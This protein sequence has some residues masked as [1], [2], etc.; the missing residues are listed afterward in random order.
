VKKILFISILLSHLALVALS[1][2][3]WQEAHTI[4]MPR[5]VSSNLL[6]TKGRDELMSM[7]DTPGNTQA[8]R[9]VSHTL[10][11][12]ESYNGANVVPFFFGNRRTQL[13]I[14]ESGAGDVNPTWLHT[15][16]AD[17][18]PYK[19][20]LKM[21][22]EREVCGV[23][24]RVT[25]ALPTFH[26]GAW[27]RI[28]M[29]LI[30][31]THHLHLT[32][33][34][35]SEVTMS[36]TSTF[37]KVTEALD[38]NNWSGGKMST[39]S[40]KRSGMDDALLQV[41]ITV[42]SHKDK[43]RYSY[44]LE[45]A[46]PVG[47]RPTG[48]YVFEP[49]L[50][51][52]GHFGFGGG[53]NSCF[54]LGMFS[55]IAV[56]WRS[57][58]QYRFLFSHTQ[59]RTPDLKGHP[60]SRFLVYMDTSQGVSDN[61]IYKAGNGVN[62]FTRDVTVLPGSTGQSNNSLVFSYNH[63]TFSLGYNGWWRSS[64]QVKFKAA[65]LRS[66]AVPAKKALVGGKQH[67]LPS[68]LIKEKYDSADTSANAAAPAVQDNEFNMASIAHPRTAS[69]TLYASYR[70]LFEWGATLVQASCGGAYEIAGNRAALSSYL[71]WATLGLE[72]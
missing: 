44:Y 2:Q 40:Q 16:G 52:A 67:W 61:Y 4:F 70:G 9:L 38:W 47:D 37:Q 19:S 17:S 30:K 1:A 28:I 69:H 8:Q 49:I 6:L 33:T 58:M 7:E 51:S 71:V 62:F 10:F 36:S 45:L 60:F 3:T 20:T 34:L 14:D 64:E 50:G 11:Y 21:K 32:E 57:H 63:H 12:Q 65:L 55:G 18:T 41:G 31:V 15:R 42:P 22:P 72:F 26:K 35:D 54:S 68:P 27:M 13:R 5:P 25:Q 48:Q 66:F 59:R 24:L 46:M 43:N 56:N 53:I 23:V 39:T 29:P